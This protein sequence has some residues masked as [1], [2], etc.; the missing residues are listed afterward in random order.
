MD[1]LFSEFSYGYTVTEELATGVLGFQKVRPL[2]PT[3]RQEA[4]PGGGRWGNAQVNAADPQLPGSLVCF[5]E[6]RV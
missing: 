2:F 6:R 5:S 3:Q 1:P 4:Q